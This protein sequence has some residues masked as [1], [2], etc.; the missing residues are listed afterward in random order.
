MCPYPLLA[1]ASHLDYQPP[2]SARQCLR[3]F[4]SG[5]CSRRRRTVVPSQEHL[6][7]CYPLGTSRF[8]NRPRSWSGPPQS[9]TGTK[10]Y[11]GNRVGFKI[12]YL[13]GPRAWTEY[14]LGL[15]LFPSD[16][17]WYSR[18]WTGA[19]RYTSTFKLAW[20]ISQRPQATKRGKRN[21]LIGENTAS[22]G[23]GGTYGVGISSRLM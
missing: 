1:F 5:M 3:R 22:N 23:F 11:P 12:L 16:T 14:Y 7:R 21:V 19:L 18:C 20:V 13:W 4:Q 9:T 15:W 6:F 17:G 2:Q 8:Q 10:P